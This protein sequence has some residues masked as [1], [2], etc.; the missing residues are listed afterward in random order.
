[1]KVFYIPQGSDASL[2]DVWRIFI[3]IPKV[4]Y[5][6]SSLKEAPPKKNALKSSFVSTKTLPSSYKQL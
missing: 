5:T 1:M 6:G 2:T 3:K 4:I